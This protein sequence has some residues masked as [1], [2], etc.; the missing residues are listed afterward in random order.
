VLSANVL[1]TAAKFAAHVRFGSKAD[2]RVFSRDVRFASN[3]GHESTPNRCPL[4]ADF[5]AEVGD[6]RRVAAGATSLS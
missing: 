1:R 6:D 2:I 5:V 4:S 3:S